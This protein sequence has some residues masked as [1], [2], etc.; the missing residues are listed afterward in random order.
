MRWTES[1][2]GVDCDL[3]QSIEFSDEDDC[4]SGERSEDTSFG[5]RVRVLRRTVCVLAFALFVVVVVTAITLGVVVSARN[6][7]NR[8]NPDAKSALV[9][10]SENGGSV[11]GK[12]SEASARPTASPTTDPTAE[13]NSVA[14]NEF[15]VAPTAVPNAV[16]SSGSPSS[17]EASSEAPSH[18]PL[19][20]SSPTLVA[21]EPVSPMAISTPIQT[22]ELSPLPTARTSTPLPIRI[23]PSASPLFPP[24]MIPTTPYPTGIP[25]GLPSTARYPATFAPSKEQEPLLVPATLP[26]SA[27]LPGSTSTPR[28]SNVWIPM[29]HRWQTTSMV[30]NS[31]GEVTTIHNGDGLKLTLHNA[32]T[33]DWQATLVRA[34]QNWDNGVPDALTLAIA[35]VEEEP[36]CEPEFGIFKICNGDYGATSWHGMNTV[37]LRGRF[38]VASTTRLNEYFLGTSSEATRLFTL[39]HEIGHGFGLPHGDED[40]SNEDT[41]SCMDYTSNP[42]NNSEPNERNYSDLASLYGTVSP[43]RSLLTS[44][45]VTPLLTTKPDWAKLQNATAELELRISNGEIWDSGYHIKL[46]DEF[47]A[48]VNV[49]PSSP[50]NP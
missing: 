44:S 35:K 10:S 5:E 21:M 22:P 9:S 46:G 42:S 28:P 15:P 13:P 37:L 29:A 25:I 27:N 14:Q 3:E 41:G 36:A 34:V 45:I 16:V 48:I 17:I 40:F 31:N 18:E 6:G 24:S 19:L 50:E 8:A 33:E 32:M 49:L 47:S 1:G 11:D 26:S 30:T 20:S 2:E 4:T 23:S 39:C 7:N 43:R 38:V 12:I